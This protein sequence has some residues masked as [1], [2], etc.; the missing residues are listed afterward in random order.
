MDLDDLSLITIFSTIAVKS[1]NPPVM[2]K[3]GDSNI[4]IHWYWFFSYLKWLI[5]DSLQ[6]FTVSTPNSGNDLS[7][8]QIH[9]QVGWNLV[10]ELAPSVITDCYKR[11]LFGPRVPGLGKTRQII[12]TTVN[13]KAILKMSWAENELD[14]HF[15]ILK[16]KV[17]NESALNACYITATVNGILFLSH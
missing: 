13:A 1:P 2:S 4:Y 8:K 15:V 16:L 10:Q 5:F 17:Q 12:F 3:G 6:Q 9:F 7:T 14:L 11:N